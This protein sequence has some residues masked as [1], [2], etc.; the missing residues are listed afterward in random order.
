MEAKS[1]NAPGIPG[2]FMAK[3][4]K[5]AVFY[6]RARWYDP[7]AKRFISED[8]IGLDG[9]INL[10]AYVGNNPINNMDPSGLVILENNTG[11]LVVVSGDIGSSIHGG[12]GKQVWG[13]IPAGAKDKPTIGGGKDHPIDEYDTREEAEKAARD[14][15]YKGKFVG[16]ITDIDYYDD[17][18]EKHKST[19]FADNQLHGDDEGPTYDLNLKDGK[20]DAH[21][22]PS[23][24]PGA[25]YRRGKE[26][27]G[28]LIDSAIDSVTEGVRKL[29]KQLF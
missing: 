24:E 8:P 1:N 3:R 12:G 7:A 29:I 13:V 4:H 21:A 5:I 2:M 19:E 28:K 15:K 18:G 11:S 16:Q 20:I 17:F 25:Y 9:G 10:Y 27:T 6:H 22:H 23:T 26:E 14:P